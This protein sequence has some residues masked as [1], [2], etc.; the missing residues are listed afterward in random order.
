MRAIRQ[1]GSEGGEAELNRPSLPLSPP[2][3]SGEERRV[4][5]EE[6]KKRPATAVAG[7]LRGVRAKVTASY[8]PPAFRGKRKT[9]K[10][11]AAA[12]ILPPP[13]RPK[14]SLQTTTYVWYNSLATHTPL[15]ARCFY[16]SKIGGSSQKAI[17]K[18]KASLHSWSPAGFG[19]DADLPI[20]P[21]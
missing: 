19:K 16:R 5:R 20:L 9:R 11:M 6:R 2:P 3:S 13:E 7:E 18:A 15:G 14:S 1:S 21:C 17:L 12:R 8:W 4:R 10:Q